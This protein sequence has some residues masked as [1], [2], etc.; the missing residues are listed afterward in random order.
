MEPAPKKLASWKR[1]AF[2][3]FVLFLW[4]GYRLYSDYQNTKKWDTTNI[5]C[6][7]IAFL[8][9]VVILFSVYWY[10]NRPETEKKA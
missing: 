7:A 3:I 6:T 8:I 2:L 5:V 1:L 9:A 4:A 10:A